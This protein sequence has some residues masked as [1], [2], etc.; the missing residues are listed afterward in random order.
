MLPSSVIFQKQ[1]MAQES[2]D[3]LWCNFVKKIFFIMKKAYACLQ[4]VCNN[5]VKFQT[6]CLKTVGKIDYTIFR[7]DGRT[8]GWTNL[9]SDR[10]TLSSLGH[11][12]DY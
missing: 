1:T 6:A 2:N 3:S 8:D 12:K 4:Y 9:L 5:C 11:K 7:G 10:Q